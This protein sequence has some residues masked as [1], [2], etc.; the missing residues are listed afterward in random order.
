VAGLAVLR[1]SDPDQP[2]R[3]ALVM[4]GAALAITTPSMQ[5]YPLLLVMLVALDGRA[6]WLAFAAG[7]YVAAESQMGQFSVPHP[8][9]AGY[10]LAAFF[11]GVV[12]V[13]RY[14]GSQPPYQVLTATPAPAARDAAM[15][16]N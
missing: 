5:W 3:G 12:W 4:T 13:V 11:V 8:R 9:A 14:V 16:V 1:F 6:E 2:W 10:A 15:T 7:A